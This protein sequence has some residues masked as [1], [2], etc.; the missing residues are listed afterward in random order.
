MGS[1]FPPCSFQK[2]HS[3]I[4]HKKSRIKCTSVYSQSNNEN[5]E[6]D[7][8]T[9]DGKNPVIKN[10]I[11]EEKQGSTTTSAD[12]DNTKKQIAR[13][14]FYLTSYII[15]FL[16]VYFS[17]GLILNLCGFGYSF[18]FNQG[19]KIDKIENI[20]IER[21]FEREAARMTKTSTNNVE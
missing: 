13:T 6:V 9:S 4:Q 20:Q 11:Q 21:Q 18:D 3:E 14:T 8:E 7:V 1:N 10:E 15:Q 19:L 16:G 5:E 12:T 2:V 17:F